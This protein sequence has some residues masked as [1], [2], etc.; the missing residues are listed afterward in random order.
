MKL[1]VGIDVYKGKCVA[2]VTYCGP[3]EPKLWQKRFLRGAAVAH[4]EFMTYTD[5]LKIRREDIFSHDGA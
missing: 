3:N 2:H 5:I 1:A 4:E